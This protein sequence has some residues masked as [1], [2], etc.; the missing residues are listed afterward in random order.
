MKRSG[1][2]ILI[3]SVLVAGALLSNMVSQE[4][5][6]SADEPSIF[7]TSL[8][9][10]QE[11]V[12][13]QVGSGKTKIV[14]L[15]VTG[16]IVDN[17]DSTSAF[18]SS[19]LLKQMDQ[20]LLD[21]NVKGVI[22]RVDSPGGTVIDSELIYEKIL[23][24][25]QAGIKVGVSMGSVAA[26]GGYY[27]SAPADF[28][29]ANPATITGSIGVIFSIP[30]YQKAADW[31]GY[32]ETKITSG[33]MKDIGNPL[34]PMTDEERAVYQSLVDES[35]NRFVETI[36]NGRD[37]PKEEVLALADGRIYSGKQAKQ[38]NLV[39]ELGSLEDS[40]AA[41]GELLKSRNYRV[42]QYLAP[43]DLESLFGSLIQSKSEST[44][45]LIQELLPGFSREPKLLYIY[46]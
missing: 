36:V 39:D 2:A 23:E 20:V 6:L 44:A 10:W 4:Q 13:K 8:G 28:I 30:N 9:N 19:I 25:Q 38:L 22:I 18:S 27:I 31:L 43:F 11:E 35:Y 40:Y 45:E 15:D 29:Y 16:V 14:L 37:L 26:S 46:E 24:L 42:V 34:R 41:M 32:S 1:W 3:I 17:G 12:V 21:E 5:K 33:N 7:S